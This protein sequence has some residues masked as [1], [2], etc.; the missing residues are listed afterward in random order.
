M[1][2]EEGELEGWIARNN[3]IAI[4][5]M[6]ATRHHTLIPSSL[7]SIP[8]FVPSMNL[9]GES[10]YYTGRAILIPDPMGSVLYRI[11]IYIPIS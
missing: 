10:F 6:V 5:R 3:A 4:A 11:L 8:P 9:D 2:D 1:L 7:T